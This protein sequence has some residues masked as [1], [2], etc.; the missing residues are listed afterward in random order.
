[1]PG[2]RSLRLSAAPDGDW[3]SDF[4]TLTFFVGTVDQR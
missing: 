4:T 1:V 3:E 2:K